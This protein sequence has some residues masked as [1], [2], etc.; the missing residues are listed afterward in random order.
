MDTGNATQELIN[1]REQWNRKPVLRDIYYEY[2][3]LIREASIEG[4]TLEVGGGSGNFKARFPEIISL[5]VV[6]LP[7]LDIIAD[8]QILP[9]R[10]G[11]IANIVMVDVLHHVEHPS[12]FFTEVERVLQ[13]GGRMI[14]IEP[15]I[16]PVS[17][18]FLTLFHPEPI[19]LRINPL[20]EH[21]RDPAREP[22]DANQAIP[23]LLFGRYRDRFEKRF[24]N[25]KIKK[26]QYLDI[27]T[28]PLS[29]G[30]RAWSL[31]PHRCLCLI[32]RVERLLLPAFGPMMAFRYYGIIEKT[33]KRAGKEKTDGS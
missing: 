14:F 20:E 25:L 6:P 28:Y 29:G 23:T 8:A 15:A 33:G 4:R 9:I 27:F 32:R 7:W 1:H 18:V 17:R 5:D 13:P 12:T 26:I 3:S 19:D 16:T 10:D 22:F 30:F 2:F 11:S 31:V 21:P 24:P